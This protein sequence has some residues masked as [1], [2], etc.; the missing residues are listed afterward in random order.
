MRCQARASKATKDQ[1]NLEFHRKVVELLF[2]EGEINQTM[3]AQALEM[4]QKWEDGKVCDPR[5]VFTWR[6]WL[7]MP[8]EFAKHAI[9]DETDL[10]LSMRCNSPL[11]FLGKP[12]DQVCR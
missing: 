6:Q 3:K 11:F 1:E 4:V 5:Y 9:L 12:E 7:D 2:A 10:G 8:P